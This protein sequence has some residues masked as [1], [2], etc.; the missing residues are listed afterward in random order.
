[1]GNPNPLRKNVK[2]EKKLKKRKNLMKHFR[3]SV[4]ENEQL[5]RKAKKAGMTES[6]L[7]RTLLIGYEPK[8]RPDERFYD[9]LE[10]L[11]HIGYNINQIVR[12][13]HI[14]KFVNDTHYAEQVDKLNDIVD[15]L[16]EKYLTPIKK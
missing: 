16:R 2:G 4:E 13:A 3:I 15:D 11:R 8:E 6:H 7:I 14:H 1:M 9:V 12:N 5:K 10:E